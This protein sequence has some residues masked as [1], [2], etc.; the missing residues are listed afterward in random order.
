[1]RKRLAFV[2]TL[3]MLLSLT[4]PVASA[5][6]PNPFVPPAPEHVSVKWMEGN[7]SPTTCVFSY[8][9]PT[10]MSAF[11]TAI[12]EAEDKAA[13]L[14]PYGLEDAWY[15]LQID[16]ALDDVD[17]PVSGWHY[18]KYWDGD[19]T[20]G[21]GKDSDA[22]LHCS[23]WDGIDCG[24]G[25]VTETVNDVW[26]LRG[27]PNDDRLNGNP[28]TGY[29]G[30]KD[31]LRPDQFTYD[32]D[33]EELEIDFT[34]HT[35]YARARFVFVVYKAG[36][37]GYT[38]YFSPWSATASCGKDAVSYKPL[39]G[40]DIAAP[41]ITDLHMTDKE[42]ND[43]PVV[44]YTLTVPDTLAK[45]AVEV[46]AQ[47]GSIVIETYARV[48]GDTDWVRMGNCDW[49][50][51]PGE[52]E[53]ALLSLISE[54][55]KKIEKDTPIELRCRY[56]CSQVGVDEDV[57]SEY[58]KILT[59]ETSE[60][61]NDSKPTPTAEPTVDEPIPTP[62]PKVEAKD[63]KKDDK[64]PLCHFCPQPLGLCIFIWLIIIVVVVLV[65]IIVVK[66]LGKDKKDQNAK[67]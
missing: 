61:G 12:D 24:I 65:A 2:L 38:Y 41:E 66:K 40:K 47:R 58:S 64:C 60:I 3:L 29:I 23:D 16:W 27:V 48:K 7:D 57:Y 31:Q 56:A 39:T 51:K 35:V 22:K 67:N 52:M 25:N 50:I 14:A 46:E 54:E 45:Q 42:F 21:L 30:L 49:E 8:S 59:F 55:H 20:H 28:E 26:I 44:A 43:N 19:K 15:T 36:D 63:E 10:S 4:V 5:D 62:T 32:Y 33:N 18:N 9:V 53:C 6:E 1:M 13:F 17:D 11:Q 34:K 37:D